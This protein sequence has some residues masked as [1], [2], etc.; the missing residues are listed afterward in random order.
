MKVW[1]LARRE[2]SLAFRTPMGYV[3][4]C[5]YALISGFVFVFLLSR[6]QAIGLETLQNPYGTLDSVVP[7]S[8]ESWL[9]QP[10]LS[11]ISQILT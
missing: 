2:I 11:N 5:V 4:L 9:V 1:V 7:I 3:L 10:Y 6:Y 8:T